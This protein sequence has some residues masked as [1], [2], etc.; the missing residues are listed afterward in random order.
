MLSY[1]K[2]SF[3]I[4]VVYTIL[5]IYTDATHCSSPSVVQE[6]CYE[7]GDCVNVSNEMDKLILQVFND[8]INTDDVRNIM[9]TFKCYWLLCEAD[10]FR[11]LIT[12]ELIECEIAVRSTY[13]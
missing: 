8:D 10:S 3:A 11:T 7:D 1:M 6:E 4:I 2:L 5:L 9:S 13:F 12:T